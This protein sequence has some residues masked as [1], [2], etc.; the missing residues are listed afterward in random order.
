MEERT[1]DDKWW[2]IIS[3]PSMRH[4]EGKNQ[5]NCELCECVLCACPETAGKGAA[6]VLEGSKC[7]AEM[8]TYNWKWWYMK[9]AEYKYK[10]TFFV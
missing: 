5:C 10:K 4:Y 3:E 8:K 9:V 1:G 2:A 6:Q 7:Q